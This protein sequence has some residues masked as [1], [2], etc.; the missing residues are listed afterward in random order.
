MLAGVVQGEGRR[1]AQARLYGAL[2]AAILEGRLPPGARLP[3]SRALAQEAGVARQTVV[4]VYERLVDEGYAS[5]RVGAGTFVAPGLPAAR[6]GPLPPLLPPPPALPDAPPPPGG[7]AWA[8]RALAAPREPW[9]ADRPAF[10]FRPGVPDWEIFPHVRWRRLL[11]RR[12][13]EAGRSPALERYGDPAGYWPLREAL[14]GYLTRSR[15]LRCTPEQVVVVS[16]SQQALDLLARVGLDPGDAAALEEPGYPPARAVLQA[17]GARLVPLAVDDGGLVTRLAGLTPRLL[18]VTPSHQYPTGATLSLT[19]RLQLL[20]W[21]AGAGT[22]VVEDD[23]DSELRYAGPPLPALQGLDRRGCVAYVGSCSSVL[24]PPLRVGWIVAPPALVAPLVAAKWLA[25]RQTPTLDQQVLTDFITGGH[26]TRHL[27]RARALYG[28]RRA[29]LVGAVARDLPACRL[30]GEAAGLQTPLYLPPGAA[31]SAV[32]RAAG[33]R[34]VGVYP[35]GPC[36][37]AGPG[38]PGLLLGYCALAEP[39]IAEGV[40]RLALAL[41]ESER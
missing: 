32:V 35:L 8:R 6:A 26:L 40:R 29:A 10:D 41:E 4:Q 3:A 34:G 38:P 13:R 24:F 30:G 36:Y 33:A 25:D 27:R 31:E 37:G 14:A 5:A 18:Y 19:R 39:A 15:G 7:S 11:A 23:Y 28:A 22:L 16:G 17:A 12:W 9:A 1:G 2:R 21:A 20:E